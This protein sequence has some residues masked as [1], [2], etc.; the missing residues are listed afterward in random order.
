MRARDLVKQA[1]I[2]N[3]SRLL[4]DSQRKELLEVIAHNDTL[5]KHNSAQRVSVAKTRAMLESLGYTLSERCLDKVC[6]EQLGRKGFT[7][8]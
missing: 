2:R 7:T 3:Q 5:G 6:R 1:K 4:S 8:P